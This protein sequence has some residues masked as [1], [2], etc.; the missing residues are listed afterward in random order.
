MIL[1]SQSPLSTQP[2]LQLMM[3]PSPESLT[4]RPLF[5]SSTVTENTLVFKISPLATTTPSGP[6]PSL[7]E[8]SFP[9]FPKQWAHRDR[10]QGGKGTCHL[11][12]ARES[13][14]T[15]AMIGPL[16]DM[17]A[18]GASPGWGGKSCSSQIK[19][20]PPPP[21]AQIGSRQ[22]LLLDALPFHLSAHLPAASTR[23]GS[24]EALDILIDRNTQAVACVSWGG[25]VAS[26]TGRLHLA[27]PQRSETPW[28]QK[29]KR[30]GRSAAQP[31][32]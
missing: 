18:Q 23:L 4:A 14:A 27:R 1:L 6:S 9:L 30:V 8:A 20:P 5:H 13:G 12:L 29:L 7:P 19:G 22:L 31:P 15:C 28:G 24:E 17:A 16:P 26:S 32:G 25:G 3:A 2:T 21:R 11:E 10:H